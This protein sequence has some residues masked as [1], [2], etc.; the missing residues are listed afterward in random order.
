MSSIHTIYPGYRD[1]T[2]FAPQNVAYI[3][4]IATDTIAKEFRQ[5]I[6]FT[7]ASIM[8]VMQRV[9][10][11][12]Y[13]TVPQMNQRVVLNLLEDARNQYL[14][15]ARANSLLNTRWESYNYDPS[16][17]IQPYD[18]QAIKLNPKARGLNFHFTF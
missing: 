2:F 1:P 11:E 7:D 12:R 17:G 4:K 9:F 5:K 8:R 18:S 6:I 16:L 15:T 3:S 10:E 13:Q 14:E